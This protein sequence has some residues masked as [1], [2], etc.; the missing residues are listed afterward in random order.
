M[1]LACFFLNRTCFNGLYRTNR[2]GKFNVA[3]GKKTTATILF[4]DEL[5]EAHTL[6]QGVEI[7]CASFEETLRDAPIGPGTYVFADAPYVPVSESA[8]FDSYGPNKFSWQQQGD[9]LTLLEQAVDKGAIVV[10]TNSWTPEIVD[11]YRR[12]RAGFNVIEI[13]AARN[14]ACKAKSREAVGEMLATT[15]R[16]KCRGCGSA[17]RSG[18]PVA[19]WDEK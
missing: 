6:L 17:V 1:A 19:V 16:T 2:A 11:L 13:S 10:S 4:E 5:H 15:W 12:S 3:W 9:L 18:C 8:S 7:R 14:I